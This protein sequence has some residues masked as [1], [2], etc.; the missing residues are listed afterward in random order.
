MWPAR[1]R[2][3]NTLGFSDVLQ[4]PG[5][6]WKYLYSSVGWSVLTSPPRR[7]PLR[8]APSVSDWPRVGSRP[9][10]S[11]LNVSVGVSVDWRMPDWR[12]VTTRSFVVS[13]SMFTAGSETD[14]SRYVYESPSRAKRAAVERLN[15]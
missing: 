12:Y 4:R 5:A 10:S 8:L 14:V 2:M 7:P 15:R 1:T 9:P 6:W 3:P 11:V 13:A